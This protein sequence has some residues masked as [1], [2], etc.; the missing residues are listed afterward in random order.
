M[1][2]ASALAFSL[3]PFFDRYF[4]LVSRTLDQRSRTN[5]LSSEPRKYYC[6]VV[7]WCLFQGIYDVELFDDDDFYQQLLKEL[8]ERKT[9]SVVDPVE[10]SRFLLIIMKYSE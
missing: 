7:L 8:I 1:W 4:F 5:D 3:L 9:A 6:I 2:K 10:M